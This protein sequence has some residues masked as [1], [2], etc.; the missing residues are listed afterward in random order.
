MFLYILSRNIHLTREL[1]DQL[2]QKHLKQLKETLNTFYVKFEKLY[3]SVYMSSM[4][5]NKTNTL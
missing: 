4:I 2:K 3:P 5:E 1:L